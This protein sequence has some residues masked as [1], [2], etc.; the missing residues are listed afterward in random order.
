MNHKKTKKPIIV[1]VSGGFDPVHIGH[2]RM[3]QAAKK[4]G[5]KLIVI[6]NNDNWLIKKKGYAFM[7]E[8]ERKE[9]IEAFRS[10]DKVVLT[11]HPKNPQDMSVC[12]ALLE[13]KPDIFANGGDRKLDNIPE[14]AVCQQIN[15][16]MVF[17]LGQGGKVQSSSWL[18]NKQRTK[19]KKLKTKNK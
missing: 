7:P 13:I 9:V 3:F 2:V 10:V 8:L 18:V 6:L 5:D 17:N 16:R 15:C 12:E 1:T 19:E 11:K 4:L 14:V